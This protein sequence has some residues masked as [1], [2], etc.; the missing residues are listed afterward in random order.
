MKNGGPL[1]RSVLDAVIA[2][3]APWPFEVL[4]VD[5]GSTDGSLEF[6][7]ER[8][9][10]VHQ[11]PPAE[12]GHG[13]TRNLAISLTTAPFVVLIT[14][15]ARP[16]NHDWL[17][18]LV[19][20][21]ERD[22]GIA[23]AFGRHLPYP[24]A[25]PYT[26]RDIT[27][28][29]DNFAAGPSVVRLDDRDRY[30][31]DQGYRQSLHYFSD[32]NACLRRSVWERFPYP[33]V[34]F[35]EDQIWAKTIIEAGYAKAYA[36]DAR[37]YHSHYYSV[38]QTLRRAYDESAAFRRLFDYDLCPSLPRAAALGARLAI[39]DAIYSTRRGRLLGEAFWILR[40]PFAQTGRQLGFYLG[41][42]DAALP[43]WLRRSISLD[44]KLQ[45]G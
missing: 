9:V 10:R 21:V 39:S 12:F 40:A 3:Q 33:D 8:G 15:D 41:G 28:H 2:Q 27:L 1:F 5:S 31:V 29:F 45:A 43:D 42:R 19:A 24:D 4:V 17:A 32:N 38:V 44:R 7:R 30:A 20:A 6:C 22:D 37:V 34:D 26:A 18:Q 14:H 13:R 35:A 11:I 36:D 23:G 16:A 25:D